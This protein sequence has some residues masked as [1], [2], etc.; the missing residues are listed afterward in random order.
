MTLRSTLAETSS[1]ARS[2]GPRVVGIGAAVLLLAFAAC[3]G[4]VEEPS[5]PDLGAG[6]GS[7]GDPDAGALL[8]LSLDPPVIRL[9]PGSEGTTT[10]LV[11]NATGEPVDLSV[12]NLP[13]G[14]SAVFDGSTGASSTLT[15][16]VA[17]NLIGDFPLSVRARVGAT[18]AS[19][20]LTVGVN[21]VAAPFTFTLATDGAKLS[22]GETFPLRV[23]VERGGGIALPIT[24]SLLTP[25][26]G[27]DASTFNISATANDGVLNLRTNGLVPRGT[28][29]ALSIRATT[30]SQSVDRTFTASL[31]AP[32]GSLDETFGGGSVITPVIDVA[33]TPSVIHSAV[34]A[35]GKLVVGTTLNNG[36]SIQMGVVR[37]NED[38]SLDETFG[39]NGTRRTS[40][41]Q[42]AQL[43][44]L[45][46]QPDGK[47]VVAG[48]D[49]GSTSRVVLARFLPNGD[50]DPSFDG[51]GML[52]VNL[53]FGIGANAT[54][55]ALA[56]DKLVVLANGGG[57]DF[58]LLRFAADGSLDSSFGGSGIRPVDIG[59]TAT[60]RG[61]ALAVVA[62][63]ITI[64]GSLNNDFLVARFAED[65]SFDP[66]FNAVGWR[67]I[68]MGVSYAIAT[69]LLVQADG[70]LVL[71][72]HN[73]AIVR[74]TSAGELDATFGAGG[75]TTSAT[76][77]SRPFVGWFAPALAELPGGKLIAAG[78]ADSTSSGPLDFYLLRLTEAGA[79]DTSF[80]DSGD[81]LLPAGGAELGSVSVAPD[82][83]IYAVGRRA[84]LPRRLFVAR[85]WP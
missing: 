55:L 12:M 84:T 66:S 46:I 50:L 15:I 2:I 44:G 74:L 47:L 71:A 25:P 38:G 10:V 7:V 36:S 72:G 41:A 29:T 83:R 64:A 17:N 28:S 37:F 62:G 75:I 22:R 60:A 40:F 70:K 30:G 51:D 52:T 69:R 33:P 16:R 5:A 43:A 65:G 32:S 82:G 42:S 61:E 85:F 6:E 77:G 59:G 76:L 78:T 11:A 19:A 27:F 56:G 79:L 18:S 57:S 73:D 31:D 9:D 49:S 23:H 21:N 1:V 14:M 4:A 35:D 39:P 53:G 34:Q 68:P 67:N 13:L 20:M 3:N 54:G 63:K 45:V 8:R 58:V 81:V 80:N 24:V 48:S 26:P